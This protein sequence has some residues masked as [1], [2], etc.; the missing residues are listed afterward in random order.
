MDKKESLIELGLSETE[1]KIYL[2]LLGNGEVSAVRI[3]KGTGIHRRTIYDNLEMLLKKGFISFKLE[4]GIRYFSANNPKVFKTVLE[5]KIHILNN[6][7]PSLVLDYNNTKED[8]KIQIL[9]GK[10]AG[11]MILDDIATSG[12]ELIW[13]GGGLY[14]LDY[15]RNSKIFVKNK[16]LKSKIKMIQPLSNNIISK[17]NEFKNIKFRILPE[18]YDSLVGFA[19]Y[20]NKIILGSLEFE[21]A[22]IIFIENKAFSNAFRN[23]FELIWNIADNPQT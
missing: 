4:D 19:V 18:K 14:L 8:F 22:I 9:K 2:Y 10:Q 3:S 16:L 12:E 6:L 13:L 23:Y 15:Y 5:E 11:K 17:I 20:G 21:E 1:S 7:M